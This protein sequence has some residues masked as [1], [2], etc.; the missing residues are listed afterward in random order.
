M[1][2]KAIEVIR[3]DFSKRPARNSTKRGALVAALAFVGAI[4][5]HAQMP[6][7]GGHLAAPDNWLVNSGQPWHHKVRGAST[8]S[9]LGN[10][11]PTAQEKV[12]VE[13]AKALFARSSAK[14]MALVDDGAIVWSETKT[15][16]T[17]EALVFGFSVGKTVTG[18]AVGQAICAG[19]LTLSSRLQDHVTELASTDLGRAT[20][21]DL[22]T[23]RSGT[24]E[25]N[26]DTSVWNPEQ[27]QAIAM[28][29]MNWLDLLKTDK[30]SAAA[31]STF[32][33]KRK[34]GEVFSYKS[35]DPIALGVAL[36]QATGTRY[37][38]WVE[39]T[40]LLPAGIEGPAAI[41]QDRAAGYGQGDGALR[42][43][44]DDWV[45][46]AVW[47][48]KSESQPGCFGDYVRD[49]MKPMTPTD[50]IGSMPDS[51]GYLTWVRGE[52]SWAIGHGGQRIAWN[53]RNGR[54][55]V[56]FSSVEDY[57]GDLNQLYAEWSSLPSL[58]I[59]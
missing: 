45:R 2:A 54:T 24:W 8:V 38:E 9:R 5:A 42:M 39:Q 22:L 30:V 43:R 50:K 11:E 41:A 10:R 25:G 7:Q 58:N 46:L 28:G 56:A 19:K 36:A 51:Y 48:R 47:V 59:P 13:K 16:I 49:S 55:L 57:M 15:P 23:M 20:V 18:L 35:T 4:S 26:K 33:G 17:P 37:A 52:S 34:P 27:A 14:A 29:R 40:V 6:E 53:R 44:F 12:V 21:Q 32:G 1:R 31:S 3:C